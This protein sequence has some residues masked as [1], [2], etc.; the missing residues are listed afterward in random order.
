M[1]SARKLALVLVA[2]LG[3]MAT[4][5]AQLKPSSPADP[6]LP[7]SPAE[8][9]KSDVQSLKE[10]GARLAAEKWLAIVDSGEYGT[11]WDQSARRFRE[12]VT[13]QQWMESLPKTRGALGAMK[14]R[15]VEV[16]SYKSSLSGMPDGDYVTVRFSSNFDKKDDA[17]EMVTLV[18]EDGTW[19]PLGYGI[20]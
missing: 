11:A 10:M 19:R 20:G 7:R 4:A 12:N 16:A 1:K 9:K 6:P 14:S 17:Q 13:R 2:L 18:F 5:T 15:R 3:T 8:E